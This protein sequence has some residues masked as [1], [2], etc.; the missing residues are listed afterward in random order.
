MATWLLAKI[1]YILNLINVFD[2]INIFKYN[3]FK[4][5]GVFMNKTNYDFQERCYLFS[6][7]CAIFLEQLYKNSFYRSPVNQALRS[8][9]SVGANIIESKCSKTKKEFA[10]FYEIALKSGNEAV[11]WI[12][13]LK[14]TACRD[15]TEQADKILNELQQL[16]KIIAASINTMRKNEQE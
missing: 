6:E 14:N 3:V 12:K 8:A 2:N 16:V 15:N 10:R 9:T 11:Y 13:L 7:E 1:T 4:T 5:G